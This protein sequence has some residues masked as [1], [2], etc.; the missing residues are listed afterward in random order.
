MTG[1]VKPPVPRHGFNLVP[2]LWPICAHWTTT[3]SLTNRPAI[4]NARL[5]TKIQ[6]Y[7]S[8]WS[9]LYHQDKGLFWIVFKTPKWK[10]TVIVKVVSYIKSVDQFLMVWNKIKLQNLCQFY[11]PSLNLP[12]PFWL[13][14]VSVFI[15]ITLFILPSWP[16]PS[17][18][19]D[20][21]LS[22]IWFDKE[23]E[24]GVIKVH[25]WQWYSKI[26]CLQDIFFI[27][28]CDLCSLGD[29]RYSLLG[30]PLQYSLCPPPLMHGQS[31]YSSHQVS[32][33]SLFYSKTPFYMFK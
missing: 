23:K 7:I 33:S 1:P 3:P 9:M 25:L 21:N 19:R 8:L 18:K 27:L 5:H 2:V 11:E 28:T 29:G 24:S 30:Q 26:K 6:S 13:R 4:W 32:T 15:A 12:S 22:E 10:N 14:Y 31:S 16:G 20:V 17:W